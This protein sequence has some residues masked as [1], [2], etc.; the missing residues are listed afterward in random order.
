MT[1][2]IRAD[3]IQALLTQLADLNVAIAVD[4]DQLRVDA[5][6]GVLTDALKRALRQHRD[7][8][9]ARLRA[10]ADIVEPHWPTLAVDAAA[11]HEPFPLSDVQHA[12]WIGRS[13]GLELGNVATHYYYELSCDDLDLERFNRALCRLID[14]HDMLRAVVDHDGRQRILERVPEYTIPVF[15][16][17]DRK[18][19]E[20]EAQLAGVR[21][22]M[23]H[24]QLPAHQWPLFDIRTARLTERN[25]RV[26]FSWDFI[27]LDA[28]S[29]Y[30]ICREWNTLYANAA[31]V[32]APIGLSYR[33]Y[34]LA[35]RALRDGDMYRRDHRYWWDRIERIPAA[36]MLPVRP[37]EPGQESTFT[38]RRFRMGHDAWEQLKARAR[39]LGITPSGILLAAYA[40]VLAYWSKQPH[41]SINLTLFSRLPL[42][43]DVD[44]LVGDFTSLTLLEVDL[45]EAASFK[46]RAA[47]LQRQFLRDFEHRLVS[48]VE[49]LREW[50]KRKGYALQA[51]MPVVFTS[52]LVLN[53]A[54]GDDAGLVESF[55]P[56]V[57]G[58]SQTPQVWLDC[59]VMEDKCG[60]VFNWDALDDAFM[61]GVLDAMYASYGS[62]LERLATSAEPWDALHPLTLPPDQALQRR[63]LN[64]TGADVSDALLHQGFVE[65]ALRTPAALALV[66][67]ERTLSYG[68]LLARSVAL[69]EQLREHGFARAQLVAI[70]IRKGWEQ[71]V[72]VLG[73]LIA[74]GAYL[75]IDPDLPPARRQQLFEQSGAR[76]AIVTAADDT[77]D[78]PAS[79]ARVVVAHDAPQ[80]PV[81]AAPPLRQRPE[82]LAYVI[83]TS[84]ST[85]VPKGVMI[86]HRGAVNTVWHVNRMFG[87]DCLDRVL[88]VSSLSFDL[89]VYDIFGL[90]T[91]G[92]AVVIPDAARTSDPEH[93][94]DLI[95]AHGVTIWNSAPPLMG[96]LLSY[97]EGFEQPP[98]GDVRL[99]LLSG[100][101]IPVSLKHKT[102]A[103][104]PKTETISLGG[105]TE[106]SIWSI[107]FP[108]TH[109]DPLWKSIPYGKPLPNQTMHVLNAQRQPCPVHTVGDIYIGGIGVALGYL[110]DSEK[111]GRQF[112][113]VDGARLYRTGDL[114]R[115]LPDGNIEFL[116]REDAQIK[117]KGH[118]IELGEIAAA[119]R[120]HPSVREAIVVVDGDSR[121][122]QSL[123]AYLQ[124][125]SEQR[126]A[127][128]TVEDATEQGRRH[129]PREIALR[130]HADE[131][132]MPLAA[133]DD[134][135][136][137]MWEAFD[138]LYTHAV[139]A[140]FHAADVFP[141]GAQRTAREIMNR[142]GIVPRYE[143][144]LGRA[145]AHLVACGVL[146]RG[147]ERY[148]APAA[149][150]AVDLT[151]HVRDLEARLGRVFALAPDAARWFTFSA[152]ALADVLREQ[153]H[154]AEIYT[155]DGTAVMYEK[156]FADCHAQLQRTLRALI[157]LRGTHKLRVLEVG[158]GLASA[159]RHVLPVLNGS[160]EA[161]E[162][163]DI[164]QYFLRR[165]QEHFKDYDFVRYQLLDID[166][167]PA[168][169][170]YE[171]HAY[172][173]VLA[174]NV[175]HDVRDIRRTLEH[176]RGLLAPGGLLLLAEVTQFRV[177]ID[178][179]A[180]VQQGFDA[181]ADEALRPLQPLL[182]REQW[183]AVLHDAGF[184]AA[185]ILNVAGT[186]TDAVG[187]DVIVAQGPSAVERVNESLLHEHMLARLPAYMRPA[188]YQLLGELP[189]TANGKIDYQALARPARQRGRGAD[190][191]KPQNEIER[192]LL[193]IWCEVLGQDDLGVNSNFFD[194]GGDS[195]LLVDVRNRI[196]QRLKRHVATT[197]LFEFPTIRSLA[198]YLSQEAPAT[199][200][201]AVDRYLHAPPS[202][203]D[204]HPVLNVGVE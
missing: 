122:D 60:L 35:E 170:G 158:G 193:Q 19:D 18:R 186:L 100:D 74:G 191:V 95:N 36:P 101:W 149:L 58:I 92:G 54:D 117:L 14:R 29:L 65:H 141:S 120:S 129:H 182:T 20:Q 203:A 135:A 41:F 172:D 192:V 33:D 109:V 78:L 1:T 17:R 164:S 57:Y 104:F 112:V 34:I 132:I 189:V 75:P 3:G 185:E 63:Q 136:M 144:W 130:V 90:L 43:Q 64:D 200:A 38:R 48:G 127:L 32:L 11:R 178:L 108:I 166:R 39:A 28:W 88:A 6:P 161:Y 173:V 66:T 45:R 30:T 98:V 113:D 73:T 181:F 51:A 15:D 77:V 188:G 67:P 83:F 42:H 153:T 139:I 148:W 105:A 16:L 44:K 114:G 89:S 72:A 50:S 31:A 24:Q 53:A 150:P 21:A 106:A 59:Q 171:A 121:A 40:E 126:A 80:T 202:A 5:P 137:A 86:D 70:A 118:R 4:G 87:V 204:R 175:L 196:K 96:M 156:L 184:A 159:T 91:A 177:A 81:T 7:T 187:F 76:L 190:I 84:G 174:A 9:V 82:D 195:L 119:L 79:V 123:W 12:Y 85:G 143:R 163:T 140:L 157:A 25:A 71:V 179:I 138:A 151:A 27:N 68:E 102:D 37:R 116:G 147:G 94:F 111:T 110:N 124:L 198:M 13:K 155:A 133:L 131:S 168:Y 49:V 180:G 142:L 146:Q 165:A 52:S 26:F 62:L 183:R 55:G 93:W 154:S 160:C 169:Q 201:D 145:L 2:E 128:M 23:S 22:Q 152:V 69:A 199:A 134:E 10:T 103:L 97:M 61:P 167:P 8:L 47:A 125:D 107:Y 194:A 99:M 56:M 162:F 197:K 46:Q 115:Y 176:L